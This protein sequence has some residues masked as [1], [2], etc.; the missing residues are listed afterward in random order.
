MQYNF[1]LLFFLMLPSSYIV[2]WIWKT[3]SLSIWPVPLLLNALFSST[4]KYTHLLSLR[5]I[6]SITGY[7]L[8]TYQLTKYIEY[9]MEILELSMIL[10]KLH[11]W[12]SWKEKIIFSLTTLMMVKIHC[13]YYITEGLSRKS[14]AIINIIR[15][16]SLTS[17]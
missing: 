17:M 14:P 11:L 8:C 5:P 1:I 10:S 13:G 4:R 6:V 2:F 15:T 12:Q 16:V 9:T 3:P 7:I